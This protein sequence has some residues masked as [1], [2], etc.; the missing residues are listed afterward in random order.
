MTSNAGL[1][2]HQVTSSDAGNYSV[3]VHGSDD[4]DVANLLRR[5]AQVFV[6]GKH[7]D[8]CLLTFDIE[9]NTYY[10]FLL[11]YLCDRLCLV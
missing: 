1:I 2:L 10:F 9:D 5:T 8:R 4:N 11:V 3:R 7:G 6:S